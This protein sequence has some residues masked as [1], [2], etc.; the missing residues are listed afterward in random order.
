MFLRIELVILKKWFI[1]L[2]F[3]QEYI[4]NKLCLIYVLL[5][6]RIHLMLMSFTFHI[7]FSMFQFSS[8]IEIS[9]TDFKLKFLQKII[10]KNLSI[11]IRNI[12]LHSFNFYLRINFKNYFD[13][14][15]CIIF[16][17]KK[18]VYSCV[19]L[20]EM[21]PY[22][23]MNIW[24]QALINKYNSVHIVIQSVISRL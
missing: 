4:K 16:W 7:L 14:L 24:T 8:F 5:M 9:T 23:Y 3:Y 6:S 12:F 10:I 11:H 2:L 18:Y 15:H 1:H 13:F 20:T 22:I 19:Y 21:F 17:V